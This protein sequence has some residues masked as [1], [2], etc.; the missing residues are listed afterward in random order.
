M[1]D[2]S[3]VDAQVTE[4]QDSDPPE[5]THTRRQVQAPNKSV[6]VRRN[7][8]SSHRVVPDDEEEVMDEDETEDEDD[9]GIYGGFS[10]PIG[11]ALGN[12]VGPLSHWHIFQVYV[13]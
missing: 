12:E 4:S 8:P 9:E 7:V 13:N 2:E 11:D 6:S 10:G 5:V 3:D 1:D